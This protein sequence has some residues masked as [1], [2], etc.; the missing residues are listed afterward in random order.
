MTTTE[1]TKAF[2]D[3][4]FDYDFSNAEERE[5][6]GKELERLEFDMMKK[7]ENIDWVITK[8]NE[9][10]NVIDARITTYQN[11]I[12]KLKKK[13][14]SYKNAGNR[15]KELII[16]L[17]KTVGGRNNNGNYQIKTD[18]KS[19]TVYNRYGPVIIKSNI[20]GEISA[21]VPD[22]FIILEQ[23]IDKKKL[24]EAVIENNGETPYAICPKVESL[25][26][27]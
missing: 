11:E 5:A 8:Q 22:N 9:I 14:N 6:I 19:Y 20:P 12:N 10:M 4:Q 15:L 23:K 25:K 27:T 16:L 26:I 21:E 7:T 13:K 1:M 17:A 24:R 18:L 2:F 3:L